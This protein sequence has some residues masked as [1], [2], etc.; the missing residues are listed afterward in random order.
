MLRAGELT[1][2]LAPLA[3]LALLYFGIFRGLR[4]SRRIVVLAVL[5]VLGFGGYLAWSGT[6][7]RLDRGER[8]VPAQL[9]GGAI[10]PGHGENPP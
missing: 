10:V 6:T 5:V 3:A 7:D 2:F 8:Y 1:V 4:V 9:R